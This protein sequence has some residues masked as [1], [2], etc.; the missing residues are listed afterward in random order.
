MLKL[1]LTK[2]I[3]VKK[4]RAQLFANYYKMSI[5]KGKINFLT[6]LFAH[7]KLY[8]RIKKKY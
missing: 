3:K 5:L 2:T 8:W 1:G 7:K 4:P 6:K